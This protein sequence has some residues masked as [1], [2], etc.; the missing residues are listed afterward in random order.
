MDVPGRIV[1]L[2]KPGHI[3]LDRPT[4]PGIANMVYCLRADEIVL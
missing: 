3:L 4:Q 1:V 2:M